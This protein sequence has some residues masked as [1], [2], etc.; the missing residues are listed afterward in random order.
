[1]VIQCQD[2]ITYLFREF[3]LLP[4]EFSLQI[5]MAPGPLG[6]SSTL[7]KHFTKELYPQAMSLS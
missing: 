7:S 2:R 5:L 6:A 4:G 1:M 3:Q